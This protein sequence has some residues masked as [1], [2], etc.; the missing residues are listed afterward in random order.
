MIA[1][2]GLL[3]G[4]I[5]FAAWGQTPDKVFYFSHIETPQG[6][7]EVTN[8]VR[9]IGD[10]R[11]VSLDVAKRSLTA[12]GT[13]DQLAVAGWLTAEMDKTSSTPAIRDFPFNDPRS[14]LAQ[15]F[16]LSHV[17][18]PR[19]LQEIVNAIRSVTDILRC[20]PMNQQKAIVMRGL[21][22]QVK[23]ADWLLSVLDQ[24]A[25][26]PTGGATS[27]DYRLAPEDWN[28]RAGELVVRVAPLAHLDTPQAIQEV[29]N[30]TRGM[31]DIQ[32]C[33]PIQSR[34][35][36]VIRGNDDQMALAEWLLKQFDGPAGQGTNE[37][38]MGGAA[39]GG[40]IAQVAYVNASTL[41]S[42]LGTVTEIRTATQMQRVFGFPAQLAVAMRGT[43][44][45]L[46]QAQQVIQSRK[47]K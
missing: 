34:R 35:V 12:K 17:D 47:G 39:A 26:A 38:K 41:E 23:A 16:Y 1:S 40:Q 31:A 18:N 30:V 20:F 43:A 46:A 5:A 7:Q 45:Q 8:V 32:R 33:F 14:P 37:F 11:D 44:D 19:D 29:T 27:R 28:T 13:A 3:A 21:P 42:L 2:K 22:G 4:L 24:P 10:I 15:I 9:A 36:L 6:L 25:G